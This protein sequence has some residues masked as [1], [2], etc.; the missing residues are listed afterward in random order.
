MNHAILIPLALLAGLYNPALWPA[1]RYMSD[2]AIWSACWSGYYGDYSRTI[3]YPSP[4]RVTIHNTSK[5]TWRLCVFDN[6]CPYTLFKGALRPKHSI[7]VSACG[8]RM[9][10]GSIS[11]MNSEGTIWFYDDTRNRT[12]KLE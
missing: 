5:Q 2:E 11:M 6:L 1:Q 4:I 9:H 10:R 3:H 8:D 12:I 7:T